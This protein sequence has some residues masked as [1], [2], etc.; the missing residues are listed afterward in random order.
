MTNSL[1]EKKWKKFISRAKLFNSIPFVDFALA[2]GSM[3]MGNPHEHSDFDVLVGVKKGRIFTA[4]FFAVAVFGLRGWRRKK[5]HNKNIDKRS[6]SDKICL[7]HWV[8]ENAYRL[9]PPHNDYWH[10][11]YQSLVPLLGSKE[12][13]NNFFESNDWLEPKRN[14]SP[15]KRFRAMRKTPLRLTLEIMLSGKFGDKVERALKKLQIER[16]EGGLNDKSNFKPRLIYSDNELE[17]HP[18]T[19]RIEEMIGGGLLK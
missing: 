15:D 5:A 3:A 10:K 18:D 14:W 12:K 2:A 17:F 16:I 19:R 1:T 11:L 13:I 6:V 8:T 9:S 4:R 7:S